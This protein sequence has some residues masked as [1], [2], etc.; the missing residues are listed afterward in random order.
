MHAYNTRDGVPS[1]NAS[2][3]FRVLLLRF[4]FKLFL[5]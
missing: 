3:H 2:D 5:F 1:S 4:S